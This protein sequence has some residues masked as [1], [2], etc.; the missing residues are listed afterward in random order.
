LDNRL[1]DLSEYDLENLKLELQELNDE[2]M[3]DLFSEF[4][5]KL[6]EEER[7][8]DKEDEVPAVQPDPIVQE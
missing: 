1:A 7:D 5:L 6:E 2:W 3:N 4:D 8:E